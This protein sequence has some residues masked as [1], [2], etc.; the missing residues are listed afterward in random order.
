MG[1]LR[2]KIPFR[3]NR[4]LMEKYWHQLWSDYSAPYS[5]VFIQCWNTETE[6]MAEL[7]AISKKVRKEGLVHYF[8]IILTEENR[9][10][11]KEQSFN[12]VKLKWLMVRFMDEN[13]TEGIEVSDYGVETIFNQ[14]STEA[15]KPLLVAFEKDHLIA[16]FEKDEHD[17]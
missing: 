3:N 17:N 1:F 2:V 7:L 5:E 10:F 15:A 14:L 6:E 12:E 4:N 8:R 11:L 9:V 13:G 16:Q